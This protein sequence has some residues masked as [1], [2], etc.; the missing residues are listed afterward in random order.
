MALLRRACAHALRPRAGSPAAH[1]GLRRGHRATALVLVVALLAG[2][3]VGSLAAVVGSAVSATPASAAACKTWIGTGTSARFHDAANWSPAGVPTATDCVLSGSTQTDIVVDADATVTS[4]DI[5]SGIKDLVITNNATFRLADTSATSRLH[6]VTGQSGRFLTDNA[7]TA[8]GELT[9][10]LGDTFTLA[11][12]G[13]TRVGDGFIAGSLRVGKTDLVG[14]LPRDADLTLSLHTRIPGQ[15]LVDGPSASSM[16][17]IEGTQGTGAGN[18]FGTTASISNGAH[19]STVVASDAR[20]EVRANQHLHVAGVFTLERVVNSGIEAQAAIEVEATG[21]L[22][23]A[24]GLT[25]YNATDDA[26]ER[27]QWTVGGRIDLPGPLAVNRAEVTYE[28]GDFFTADAV[29]RPTANERVLVVGRTMAFAG[30]SNRIGPL[31][32]QPDLFI[33]LPGNQNTLIPTTMTVGG[34]GLQSERGTVT[35]R[36]GHTLDC[37][38]PCATRDTVTT[39]SGSVVGT[40]DVDD[41]PGGVLGIASPGR[42]G[43]SLPPSHIDRLQLASDAT[44]AFDVSVFFPGLNAHFDVDEAEVHGT[45]R[46]DN[47][48]SDTLP[49]VFQ[50]G[51]EVPIIRSATPIVGGFDTVAF[52]ALNDGLTWDLVITPTTITAV[53]KQRPRVSFG[54]T[55]SQRIEGTGGTTADNIE[56]ALTS[57][58]SYPTK[59]A[60]G[61]A[62]GTATVNTDFTVPALASGFVTVPANA[63]SVTVPVQIVGDAI[64]EPD[65]TFGLALFANEFYAKAPATPAHTTTIVNDDGAAP[66]LSIADATKTEGTALTSNATITL[67][68]AGSTVLPSTVTV[69]SS[70]GTATAGSDYT[71]VSTTVTFAA[72]ETTKS[73]IVPVSGDVVPEADETVLLTLSNPTNGSLGTDIGTLTIVNDDGPLPVLSVADVTVTEG[74]GGTTTAT[75]TVTR[76]GS[77]LGGINATVSVTSGSATAGS[78]FTATTANLSFGTGVT[79]RTFTVAITPDSVAE[80]VELANVTITGISGATIGQGTAAIQIRD[81]DPAVQLALANVQKVE[82]D[83]GTTNLTLLLVRSTSL[84]PATPSVRVATANGTAAAPGDYTAVDQTVTFGSGNTTALVNIPI[85]GDQ[86]AEGDETFTVALSNP[87]AGAVLGAVASTTVKI[88]DDDGPIPSLTVADQE[89]VEPGGS[90]A[91]RSIRVTRTGGTDGTVVFRT[92]V[93]AGSATNPSDVLTGVTDANIPVGASFVDVPVTLGGDATPEDDEIFTVALSNVVGATVADGTA[94]MT[95]HDDDPRIVVESTAVSVAEGDAGLKAATVTLRRSTTFGPAT[96]S[97]KIATANG[98]ATGGTDFVA[99]AGTTVTF[100]AGSPTATVNLGINGDTTVEPDETFTATISTPSAGAVI[101]APATATVTIANDDGPRFHALSPGRLLDSRDGTGTTATKWQAAQTRSVQITGQQGVPA[102]GVSAVVLNVT[103]TGP[104]AGSHLRLFPT[105]TTLPNA[106]SINFN[107]GQTIANMAVVKLGT[108]GKIDIFNN[109]GQVDVLADVVGYYDDGTA[110]G[111]RYTALSPG[112]LLDSRDGTGTTATKWQAAQTRSVQITGQQGVPATGVSAVVLNVTVTG[113]TAGSHLRLF[114]TG[115]AVPNASSINFDAGQTI[116][117]G[118][119]VKLGT[120][121]RIDVFNNSGQVD[122]IADVVGY[123]SADGDVFTPLNPGRLLDSRD[124]TGTT[125]TKWQAAQTRSVQITGQQGVPATGVSAVVLNVTV[126]G[127]TAGSHLRLFP[128]GTTLPNASSINFN[129]GQTVANLVV[130]KV[131]AGGKIDIFNNS[132]QVDVIADVVG[133]FG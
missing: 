118:A 37:T 62:G 98:T 17:L 8:I 126:T 25:N 111:D 115:T 63:R 41:V 93:T 128:T 131:G 56:V 133:W 132:G 108:G 4:W 23:F 42:L 47:A 87:S 58:F 65:E 75:V 34:S 30:M 43:S 83:T 67:S 113:P 97:V 29:T 80:P 76:T 5:G 102:T 2:S 61:L 38:V 11:G 21:R 49:H 33:G 109:S 54:T 69:T 117:N 26:L 14:G 105:G 55:T 91:V 9:V 59:V 90:S 51:D 32:G 104:T 7:S 89:L 70:N 3:V 46:L 18:M 88:V 36:Q 99:T 12:P 44:T 48:S 57:A 119:V 78:D 35:L 84:G 52:S 81:D 107:G 77:S 31:A 110:G 123:Y 72:G 124:G 112:R 101:G 95:I 64:D 15:I 130:V 125:A 100:A 6:A 79:T 86:T 39:L 68:R 16:R 129:G 96:P 50:A 45:L 85:K 127:P 116:A 94:T 103:V 114:P 92:T 74:T 19:G 120:G 1:G 71:A 28:G 66:V 27:G 24:S 10:L 53:V 60:V 22:T 73:V 13:A 82:G 122:V 20:L 106:S 40:I 121:G